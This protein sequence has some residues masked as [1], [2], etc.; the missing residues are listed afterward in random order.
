LAHGFAC[1]GRVWTICRQAQ[2]KTPNKNK[3]IKILPEYVAV[4][5]Q[6]PPLNGS[7]SGRE[8]VHPIDLTDKNRAGMIVAV[9]P[10]EC[11]CIHIQ[12]PTGV[13]QDEYL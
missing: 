1:V 3:S 5:R 2:T 6:I 8:I 7:R 12:S 10:V 9:S 4:R 11:I 13:N